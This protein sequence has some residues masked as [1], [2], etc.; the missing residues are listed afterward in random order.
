MFDWAKD[1]NLFG[2]KLALH[3]LHEKINLKKVKELG[4]SPE[5]N[6][7]YKLL[8]DLYSEQETSNSLTNFKPPSWFTPNLKEFPYIDLFVQICTNE[9]EGQIPQQ[10][11]IPNLKIERQALQELCSAS[12]VIIKSSD[13]GGNIVLMQRDQYINM[14]MQHLTDESAYQILK[15]DPTKKFLMELQSLAQGALTDNT[16]TQNEYRFIVS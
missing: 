13:K 11:Y 1:V 16:I 9:L 3:A 7:V 15:A 2:R 8:T 5:D 10:S 4:L 14:C 6:A 12:E